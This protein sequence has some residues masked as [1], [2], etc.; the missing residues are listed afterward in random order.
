MTVIINTT[1]ITMNTQ[2]D[3]FPTGYLRFE[4][5]IIQEVGSME[6]FK[7][8][9][10]ESV[11][12][13][14]GAILMPGMIN[15]HTH[16]AMIPFR[17]MQDD[18]PDRLR[19]F[20]LPAEEKEMT[21]ELVYAASKYAMAELLLSGVTTCMD[22]YYFEKE[23][24]RAANEMGLRAVLGETILDQTTCDAKD[25]N[26]SLS[27]SE[28]LLKEY[29]NHALITPCVAPH[30][31]ITCSEDTLKKAYILSNK[32]EAL[33]TLHLSEMDYELNYFRENYQKT[34]TEYL[35]SLG[36]VDER[37]VGA[38]CIRMTKH[39]I[40]I[41]KEK[42]AKVSHCIGSNT[43]AAKG[44]APIKEMIEAG[45]TISLGTDG[46]SSGN[47]L[48]L[49]TQ[50]KLCAN[51]HKTYNHD[52]SAFPAKEIISLGTIGGA[53][54]LKMEQ[55]VGS[56]EIGKQADF[57]LVETDSVNMFPLYDPYSALV[58]SANS[59]NVESV[60]IAGKCLVKEK[61]LVEV[62]LEELKKNVYQLLMQKEDS[63]FR[64]E[65]LVKEKA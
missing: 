31:T 64:N 48:D 38:H 28:E 32:Y 30:S 22:M 11:I 44:V 9:Q 19:R 36:I 56:L 12:D 61:K 14:K 50:F 16:L 17:G 41:M 46:A 21:K 65:M 34:P 40:E 53:K 20:L 57:V 7:M 42:K 33:Y 5:D 4:E 1:I 54:S 18:T 15:T 24:A 6:D 23:V 43:K 35:D 60:Y 63:L 47:T 49:F 51:F 58:Y 13:G 25:R 55:K 59:K 3:M 2:N 62:S 8:Q 27:Y 37:F 29:R 10:G 52:R 26:E 39:D 45:I